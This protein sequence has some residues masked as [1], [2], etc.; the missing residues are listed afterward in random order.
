MTDLGVGQMACGVDPCGLYAPQ[1]SSFPQGQTV[2][3]Q[4]DGSA[5]NVPFIDPSTGDYA[6]DE[7]GRPFGGDSVD[8]RVYLSLMTTL[9][10]SSVPTMGIDRSQLKL[11]NSNTNT[12]AM[13]MVK[14]ALKPSLDAGEIS[15]QS[16]T[17]ER[18]RTKRSFLQIT[19]SY[20]N[21]PLQQKKTL[22]L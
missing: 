13:N 20:V 10:M 15:L 3:L 17:V 9:G 8:Q 2:L 12:L 14:K 7:R 16:V 6:L 4:Q 11:I 19:V 21:I 22:S 1:N 18:D 5:G